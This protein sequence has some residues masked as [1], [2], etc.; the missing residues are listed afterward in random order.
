MCVCVRHVCACV[1]VGV[2]VCVGLYIYMFLSPGFNCVPFSAI[3]DMIMKSFSFDSN[4]PPS[5][6][7]LAGKKFWR[8]FTQSPYGP[9]SQVLVFATHMSTIDPP[10]KIPSMYASLAQEAH[11]GHV[12]AAQ[13]QMQRS[14]HGHAH[15]PTHT[16]HVQNKVHT[17]LHTHI[18]TRTEVK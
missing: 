15:A 11:G 9:F 14:T 13:R 7:P 6:Q 17:F 3:N 1:C 4:K 2:C 18:H 12:Q 10:L 5:K 16:T 8:L